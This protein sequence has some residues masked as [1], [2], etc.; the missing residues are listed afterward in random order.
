MP[1]IIGFAGRSGSGKDTAFQILSEFDP[2]RKVVKISFAEPLK[3]GLMELFGFPDLSYFED[4]EKKERIHDEITHW[5][6]RRLMQWM[7][8]DII[9]SQIDTNHWIKLL[10]KKVNSMLSLD[11]IVIIITDVRF[12]EE[13]DCINRLNGIV[14]YLDADERLGASSKSAHISEQILNETKEKCLLVIPNNGSLEEY[15]SHLHLVFY[16]SVFLQSP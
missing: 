6:P 4:S 11:D 14:V 15:K 1:F 10:E 3:R 12:P 2:N 9:K 16:N 8:T 7:G 13:V 5:T